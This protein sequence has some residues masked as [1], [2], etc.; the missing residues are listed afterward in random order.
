MKITQEVRDFAAKQNAPANEF[1]AATPTAR[2]EPVEASQLLDEASAEQGMAAMSAV[3]KETGGELYM[4]SR[5]RE[6][7]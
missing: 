7:D 3:F 2:A 5:G 4:G 6:R 1:L